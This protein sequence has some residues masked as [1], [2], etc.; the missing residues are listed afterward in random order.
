VRR[1]KDAGSRGK[2]RLFG[3]MI[4]VTAQ[5]SPTKD[6]S[7]RLRKLSSCK[8]ENSSPVRQSSGCCGVVSAELKRTATLDQTKRRGARTLK[9]G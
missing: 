3:I 8:S 9:R 4:E 6:L 5:G 2:S 7:C 1:K